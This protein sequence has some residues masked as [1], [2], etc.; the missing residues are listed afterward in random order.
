MSKLA[1]PG[2]KIPLDFYGEVGDAQD[3]NGNNINPWKDCYIKI[4]RIS[5]AK[6]QE[7]MQKYM[8]LQD[9]DGGSS[10]EF[11]DAVEYTRNLIADNFIEGKGLDGD[12]NMVDIEKDDIHN[13]FDRTFFNIA[14]RYLAEGSRG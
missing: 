12:Y 8:N 7:A 13:V 2:I 4:E 6:F 3:E 11:V 9:S 10:D 5:D 1:L 14:L